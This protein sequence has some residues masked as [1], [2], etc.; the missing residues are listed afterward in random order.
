[1]MLIIILSYIYR[2]RVSLVYKKTA[3]YYPLTAAADCSDAMSSATPVTVLVL[4]VVVVMVVVVVVGL[5]SA[6][7]VNTCALREC[8][9]VPGG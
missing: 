6:V 9:R 7:R 4:V 8:P 3:H 5:L 2:T 1:M